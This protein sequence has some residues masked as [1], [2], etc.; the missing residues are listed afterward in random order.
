MIGVITIN[1]NFKQSFLMDFIQNVNFIGIMVDLVTWKKNKIICEKS[2]HFMW[3]GFENFCFQ[4]VTSTHLGPIHY[5][6]KQKE[7]NVYPFYKS[8][9]NPLQ[10]E[11]TFNKLNHLTEQL[12]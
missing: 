3:T 4:L 6:I 1:G 9:K 10:I 7:G 11:N 12:N 8:T 5:H 2:I